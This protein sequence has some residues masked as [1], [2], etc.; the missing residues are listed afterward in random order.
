M[1]KA[2]TGPGSILKPTESNAVIDAYSA[3]I[4]NWI[5]E[6]EGYAD[7][8]VSIRF[9]RGCVFITEDDRFDSSRHSLNVISTLKQQ[10]LNR[11]MD[12]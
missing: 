7:E 2:V 12:V 3:Q 4:A 9:S 5:S 8:Y 10:L 6:G 11:G 1:I